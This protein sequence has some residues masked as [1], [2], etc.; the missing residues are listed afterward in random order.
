MLD[1]LGWLSGARGEEAERGVAAAAHGT[2]EGRNPGGRWPP[3]GG[4]LISTARAFNLHN[5]PHV[6]SI[7][8]A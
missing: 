6:R 7:K 5:S 4:H 3:P 1:D 2:G 8:W